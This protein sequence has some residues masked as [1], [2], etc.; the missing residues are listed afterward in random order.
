METPEESAED[1]FLSDGKVRP[2][3]FHESTIKVLREAIRFART[4]RWDMVRS[5]HLFMG[6]LA[7]PDQGVRCW[8]DRLGANLPRLLEQF[9]EI[10]HQDGV[11][12]EPFLTMTREFFSDNVLRFLREARYRAEDQGRKISPIDILISLF[13]PNSV[14]ADCFEKIGVTTAKLTELAVIA[15]QQSKRA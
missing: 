6:L 10:F 7:A 4:T 9:V 14:V 3:L 2:E 15:E 13:A 5:P 12:E 1:L 11:D 8:G